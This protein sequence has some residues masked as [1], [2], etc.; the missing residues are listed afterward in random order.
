MFPVVG[1]DR[2][3]NVCYW[4]EEVNDGKAQGVTATA[5]EF[6]SEC[7]DFRGGVIDI[8]GIG[9]KLSGGIVVI[10]I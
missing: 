4:G 6:V 9:Y 10:G 3:T 1:V 8:K 5:L 7:S 2:E